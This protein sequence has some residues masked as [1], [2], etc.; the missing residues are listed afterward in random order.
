M[1]TLQL[2]DWTEALE[3]LSAE[4]SEACLLLELLVTFYGES[5]EHVQR[6]MQAAVVFRRGEMMMVDNGRERPLYRVIKDHAHAI[7]GSA[8]NL[9]L[10]R[11]AKVRTARAARW[12]PSRRGR[13]SHAGLRR[14]QRRWNAGPRC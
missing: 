13:R 10:W 14:R 11:L 7:K 12:T 1:E 8:A 6:A 2:I 3:A 4:P 5:L 9:R